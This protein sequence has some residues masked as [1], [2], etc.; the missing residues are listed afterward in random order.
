MRRRLCP[1]IWREKALSR[2]VHVLFYVILIGLPLTGWL[3]ISAGRD[4]GGTTLLGGLPWPFLP[5]IPEG[6]REAAGAAHGVLVKTTYAL[7]ILHVGAA[8]KH[9]FIDKRHNR[10]MPPL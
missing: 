9:Q 10:R 2:L 4:G 8:L 3:I 5:G 7:I 1:P 6:A